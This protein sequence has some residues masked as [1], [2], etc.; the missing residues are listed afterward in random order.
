MR[1]GHG[2]DVHEYMPGDH[3]ILAA[4]KIACE[5]SIKAHSDGDIV[6]HAICDA[7]LGAI[8]LGDIGHFFSDTDDKNKN[9]DSTEFLTIIWQKCRD[10]GYTLGNIDVTIIAQAPKMISHLPAMRKNLAKFLQCTENRI[11]LKATTTEGLGYIGKKQGIATHAV[12]LLIEE[13]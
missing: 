5:Y 12:V 8:G 11:N 13:K 4:T 10:L 3:M 2:Y 7:L 1:I 6:M 9:R